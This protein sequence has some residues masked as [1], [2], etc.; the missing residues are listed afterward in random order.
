MI[1]AEPFNVTAFLLCWTVLVMFVKSAKWFRYINIKVFKNFRLINRQ[2]SIMVVAVPCNLVKRLSLAH[3]IQILN[4]LMIS[5]TIHIRS[6]ECH[7]NYWNLAQKLYWFHQGRGGFWSL[8]INFVCNFLL[9]SVLTRISS[10]LSVEINRKILANFRCN[11]WTRWK[12]STGHWS[13]IL[14]VLDHLVNV[15]HDD[16]WSETR[17]P[18]TASRL[19]DDGVMVNGM[20]ERQLTCLSPALF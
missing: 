4:T 16:L 3:V 13:H 5:I 14:L 11:T 10:S 7:W 12:Q 6:G 17:N 8:L 20:R 19:V 2:V 9:V 18:T 15:A 1:A